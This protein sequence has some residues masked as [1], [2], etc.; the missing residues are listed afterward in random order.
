[1]YVPA[2]FAEERLPVLLAFL[3]EHPFGLLITLGSSQLEA[4]S[5]PFL[6]EEQAGKVTLCAHVARANPVWREARTDLE[7]LVVF[8]GPHAYVTPG[9]YPSKQESGTVVPT[10]NYLLVQARGVLRFQHDPAWLRDHVGS[11]TRRHEAAQSVPW[12]VEDAPSDFID[13]LL[14][15]IVGLEIACTSVIGKWKL[16]QNRSEPD[17]A[18]V[19]RGFEQQG[20]DAATRLAA[21][22]RN[23]TRAADSSRT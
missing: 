22:M 8:Q 5:V 10:W 18:G 16:S 17:R 14:G 13:K 19:E 21:Y 12:A 11:L 15:G 2:H 9:W 1:M 3:R 23:S 4:T 20:T 6:V 7:G